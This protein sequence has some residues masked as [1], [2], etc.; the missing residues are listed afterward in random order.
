MVNKKTGKITPIRAQVQVRP[1]LLHEI[2]FPK[3]HLPTM[4]NTLFPDKLPKSNSGGLNKIVWWIK[5]AMGL[6]PIPEAENTNMMIV[7]G[8]E[9]IKN[10]GIGIKDDVVRDFN[11]TKAQYKAL[12]L[13]PKGE[14]ECESL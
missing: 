7:G 4:I 14:Y 5:K 12:G 6:K 2:V 1:I 10:I 9:G 13:D 3:E 11:R 8:Q